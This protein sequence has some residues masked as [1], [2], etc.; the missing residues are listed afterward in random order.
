MRTPRKAITEL[1]AALSPLHTH[2]RGL[3]ASRRLVRLQRNLSEKTYVA[4]LENL[5]GLLWIVT[6]YIPQ[7]EH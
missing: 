2:R 7:S 5:C 6:E 4:N 3:G 1:H